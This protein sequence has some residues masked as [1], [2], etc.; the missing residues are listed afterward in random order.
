MNKISAI[1]MGIVSF[2]ITILIYAWLRQVG[3]LCYL[4]GVDK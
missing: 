2:L 1:I 4:I 3:F